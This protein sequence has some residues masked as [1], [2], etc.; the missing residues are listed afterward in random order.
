MRWWWGGVLVLVAGCAA[1][2]PDADSPGAKV[3]QQRCTAC[4]AIPAPGSMTL[5]MWQMQLD[6]MHQLFNQLGKPWLS[7]DEES[8]LQEYLRTHSGKQ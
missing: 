8:A 4:H 3:L 6:R 1:P 7:A 5:A 2:L